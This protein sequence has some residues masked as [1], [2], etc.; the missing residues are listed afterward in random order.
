MTWHSQFLTLSSGF[1]YQYPF[2]G[3]FYW[4]RLKFLV[5][6]SLRTW[7]SSNASIASQGYSAS[8][9]CDLMRQSRICGHR[10]SYSLAQYSSVYTNR[11]GKWSNWYIK[12]IVETL[13]N[14]R[15]PP[16]PTYCRFLL[17]MALIS[18]L[19]F[20]ERMIWSLFVVTSPVSVRG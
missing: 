11:G 13:Q 18:C 15:Q 7:M 9:T 17:S 8:Q 3:S 5:L 4:F 10:A 20:L 12:E 19:I 14:D 16:R 2:S 1:L 6:A